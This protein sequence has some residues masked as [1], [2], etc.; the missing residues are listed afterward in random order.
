MKLKRI[1]IIK[2]VHYFEANNLFC[3]NQHGFRASHSCETA[4]LSVID[5]W[6]SAIENKQINLALFVDFKK[7]FDLVNHDLLFLKLFH[8]GFDNN[9]LAL[10][11]NYFQNRSQVTKIDSY[12]SSPADILLRAPQGWHYLVHGLTFSLTI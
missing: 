4:L 7:A 6:K 10:I 5:H 11:R 3:S 1:F 12:F 8:Y 9:S 2:I